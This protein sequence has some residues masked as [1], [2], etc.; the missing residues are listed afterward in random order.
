MWTFLTLPVEIVWRILDHVTPYTLICSV[1]NVC[2]RLDRI[3]STYQPYQEL[4]V[5]DFS[6]NDAGPK[7]AQ[8]LSKALWNNSTLTTLHLFYNAMGDEGAQ[9]LSNG[10]RSNLVISP[11]LFKTTMRSSIPTLTTLNVSANRIKRRGAQYF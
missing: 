8:C 1:P 7:G 6:S 5:L 9:Y 3:L 4:T 2:K 10:I 11:S